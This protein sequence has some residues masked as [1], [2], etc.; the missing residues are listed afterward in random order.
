MKSRLVNLIMGSLLHDVGKIVHRTGVM[1]KHSISG[2]EFL[3]E[4]SSFS[5]NQD[6]KESVKYHHRRELSST[7]LENNSLSYIVYIADNIS[8]GSDR[9]KELIEGDEDKSGAIFNRSAPLASVFNL[10]NGNNQR[11]DYDYKMIGE[12]NYPRGADIS[13]TQGQYEQART[14]ISEQLKGIEVQEQYINSVLHLLEVVTSF[15]PSSTNTEELMDISLFDHSKTTAAIASC[16]YYYLEASNS[17]DYKY[18]LFNNEAEFKKKNVFLFCSCDISGIQKFIY[19]ISG[20]KGLKALRA[21]SLYLEILLEDIVDEL[22]DKLELSRCNLIYSG[23][24]HA[25]IL[26]PNTQEVKDKLAK[27]ENDLK[28]W[29]LKCFDIALFIAFGYTECS[30]NELENNVGDVYKRVGEEVAVKKSKR[31]SAEDIIKLN[32]TPDENEDRECKECKKSGKVNEEKVCDICQALIDISS[33]VIKDNVYF[34]IE[35]ADGIKSQKGAMPLPFGRVMTVKN[36]DKARES[37]YI[38]IYSKNKP[39]MGQDFATNLWVGDYTSKKQ[40]PYGDVVLEFE[41]FAEEAKGINRIGV[42]RADVDNLGKAFIYGFKEQKN[43]V[44][45][46]NSERKYETISRTATLSRELS[47]FFKFYI[48]DIL[49]NKNRKALIVYSGGDDMFIV[50]SWNDIVDLAKDIQV[51]FG[52]YTQGVLTISAGI[53][54]YHHSYPIA[55]IAKEVGELEDAAKDK[56]ENKNKVT[57]F[58]K[59][60]KDK[61]LNV[62]EQDWI[63]DWEDLPNVNNERVVENQRCENIEDKLNA[64]RT[65]FANDD[66][67]GKAFLYKML[68]LIR[69]SN[70]DTINIARY[71]YLIRR[72]EERK[73]KIDIP[74]SYRWIQSREERRDLEIAI[75]LYSYET[76]D[77]D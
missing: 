44:V 61:Y 60:K 67:Q 5:T 11:Y 23:G 41:D 3:S 55:R 69:V 8:A 16:I 76:R 27:F 64:L 54:I 71:A 40:G 33:E 59:G 47:M 19:T 42:L 35:D 13:L 43:G 1:K 37:S 24:G 10:L 72:A 74:E 7:K 14:K 9:R 25:Y 57:L 39:S 20:T 56:D 2:W 75:T 58:Q 30:S 70:G 53:G 52:Q 18:E 48:N 68:D 65:A 50:G 22:L 62:I 46:E 15:I 6:I 51:A 12:I 66:Q 29:F 63:L 45:V 4:I 31:Y 77:N 32:T 26:L 34:V 21:R 38:R 73:N 36:I 17:D 49:K 28:K